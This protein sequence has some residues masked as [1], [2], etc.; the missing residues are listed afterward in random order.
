MSI[1]EFCSAPAT[2]SVDVAAHHT[3]HPDQIACCKPCQTSLVLQ[4]DLVVA[5]LRP[6]ALFAPQ[7]H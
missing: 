6:L 7:A 2:D 4:H 5:A 1:C 3:R